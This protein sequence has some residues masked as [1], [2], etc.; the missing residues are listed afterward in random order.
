MISDEKSVTPNKLADVK[1]INGTDIMLIKLMMAVRDI[2]N[3]TS[4]VFDYFTTKTGSAGY[5]FTDGDI[6]FRGIGTGSFSDNGWNTYAEVTANP[7][8]ALYSTS[9]NTSF[10]DLI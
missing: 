3:A 9:Y 4:T 10:F 2:D 7:S 5:S 6:D 1:T 8:T